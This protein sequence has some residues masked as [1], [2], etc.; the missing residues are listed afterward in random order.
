MTQT[1]KF[2][3]ISCNVIYK[4]NFYFLCQNQTQN[5][6][7][8]F[9]RQRHMCHIFTPT[10]GIKVLSNVL[11][12]IATKTKIYE[13]A[14]RKVRLSC[15]LRAISSK[16]SYLLKSP[17]FFYRQVNMTFSAVQ[18]LRFIRTWCCRLYIQCFKGGDRV[19]SHKRFRK[20]NI[21]FDAVNS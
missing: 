20:T 14:S 21:Y 18:Y 15:K 11:A 3:T 6:S 17:L 5:F 12:N 9:L 1:W 10:S 4:K 8:S 16:I 7:T 13:E 2:G 19:Q